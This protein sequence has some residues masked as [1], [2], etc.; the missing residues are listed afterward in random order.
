MRQFPISAI[1]EQSYC[2]VDVNENPL[3]TDLCD[4]PMTIRNGAV[5]LP[6]APGLVPEPTERAIQKLSQKVMNQ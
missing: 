3:R 1:G 4:H 6:N 2:E 5:Q